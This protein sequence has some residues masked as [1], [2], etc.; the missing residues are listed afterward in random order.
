MS[1][2]HADMHGRLGGASD[3]AET[4]LAALGV[5]GTRVEEPD[6][7]SP[8]ELWA[9]CGA[10]ALTGH[11]Q[12]PPLPA[13]GPLAACAEG[14]LR[15]MRTLAPDAPLPRDGAALLGE[16]AA[17]FGYT[18][19]G[20]TSPG[21]SCRLLRCA[22]GWVALNLARP[23]DMAALPAW[24]ECD[25]EPARSPDT[26]DETARHHAWRLAEQGVT[27]RPSALLL[28]R[29]RVLSIPVALA[30]AP[31]KLPP[32]WIYVEKCGEAAPLPDRSPLVVDLSSLW[33]GP[34]CTSLLRDA[35]ARVIKV[36]SI[37][38]PDGARGNARFFDL[39]NGGKQSVALDF[40]SEHGRR[41]LQVLIGHADI[42]VESTRPRALSQL[43][44]DA[45][46]FLAERAGRTWLSITGY[47]RRDPAPGRV[48]F[49]DDAAVAAGLAWATGKDE[50]APLFCS[51][52]IADPLTGLHAA[53]AGLW[54]WQAGGGRL[55]DLS[56]RDVAGHGLGF[57]PPGET[58]SEP[59]LPPRARPATQSAPALGADTDAVLG[60][61]GIPC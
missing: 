37:G 27:H 59:A 51:D 48:A 41:A 43:G 57:G 40:R 45:R 18:R 35:G 34:L 49:G 12:G 28:E 7:S 38:R 42:V 23:D 11:A 58:T 39:M 17:C 61:L 30:A 2:I 47:G 15:A 3:Y 24:L 13:P 60:E 20:R 29:A 36:E 46:R 32:D 50:S 16:H 56:L 53:F 6:G 21:G 44:I 55:L 52:A 4:L 26:N 9:R 33:A 54:S 1:E 5:R 14:A 10:M 25:A 22:D 8:A 19:Q 31:P